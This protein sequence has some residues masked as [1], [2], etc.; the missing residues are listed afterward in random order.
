MLSTSAPVAKV[1]LGRSIAFC[2]LFL[3]STTCFVSGGT[4]CR[5]L[6]SSNWCLSSKLGDSVPWASPMSLS[7]FYPDSDGKASAVANE[8]SASNSC[9]MFFIPVLLH[10]W[11][12]FLGVDLVGSGSGVLTDSTNLYMRTRSLSPFLR[13]RFFKDLKAFPGVVDERC[14]LQLKQ[15]LVE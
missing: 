3:W 9:L 11:A 12:D 6:G 15:S 1:L 8:C 14:E 5:C 13:S 10:I 2:G 7:F 4:G